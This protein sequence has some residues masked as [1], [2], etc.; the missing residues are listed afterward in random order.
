MRQG[1]RGAE[2]DKRVAAQMHL[3]VAGDDKVADLRLRH[4]F[5]QACK[6]RAVDVAGGFAGEAQQFEFVRGFYG[7]AADR[8]GISGDEIVG[9][10]GGAEMIEEGEGESLFDADA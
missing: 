8:D 1:G 9:R 5:F 6:N 4:S 7:A 10:R 3:R 2:E